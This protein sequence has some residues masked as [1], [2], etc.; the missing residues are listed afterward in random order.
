MMTNKPQAVSLPCKADRALFLNKADRRAG[1]HVIL[2]AR[3]SGDRYVILAF[4]PGN[5][6]YCVWEA[7][8]SSPA[9][10]FFRQTHKKMTC[11]WDDYITRRS[12]A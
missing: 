6:N 11:A 7:P 10:H 1:A 9:E 5:G 3:C 4:M 8:D 12:A 2:C